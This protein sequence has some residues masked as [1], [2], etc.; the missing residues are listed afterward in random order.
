MLTEPWSRASAAARWVLVLGWLGV[1]QGCNRVPETKPTPAVVE[2]APQGPPGSESPDTPPVAAL[3][4]LCKRA[5]GHWVQMRFPEPI[6]FD[7]L[8]PAGRERVVELLE[9]QRAMNRTECESNCVDAKRRDRAACIL[10]ANTPEEADG[11]G[12]G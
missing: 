10:R 9:R 12:Q 5:C 1:W 6:G 4:D 11:C 2:K 3:G 7:T 8:E